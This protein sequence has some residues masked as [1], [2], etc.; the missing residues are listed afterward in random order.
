MAKADLYLVLGLPRDASGTAIRPAYR[1]LAKEHHPD[2]AGTSRSERFRHVS[3]A[4]SVLSNADRRKRY[5]ATLEPIGGARGL[6]EVPSEPIRAEG[7]GG[8]V[9]LRDVFQRSPWRVGEEF[10]D[11]TRRNVRGA[12]PKS[13]RRALLEL[14]V[15]LSPEEAALGGTLRLRIPRPAPCASCSGAGRTWLYVCGACHGDG[16]VSRDTTLTV[17]VPVGVGDGTVWDLADVGLGTHLRLHM[18]VDFSR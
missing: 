8:E 18:R 14:D 11:W 15:V 4:Y 6:V 7:V 16:A 5:D 3:E 13:G 12:P 10:R 9:S 17:R 1:R 2:R